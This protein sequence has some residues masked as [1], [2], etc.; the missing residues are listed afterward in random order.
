MI[1]D[2][3]ELRSFIDHCCKSTNYSFQ[4][5]KCSKI[6]CNLCKPVRMAPSK[7]ESIEFLPDPIPGDDG[8]Y[9]TFAD[10]YGSETTEEHR[11]SLIESKKKTVHRRSIDF[12]STRQHVTNVVV[13]I[14]CEEYDMWRLLFCRKKLNSQKRKLL[15]EFLED[16]SYTC[17]DT[18]TDYEMPSGLGGICIKDHKCHDTIEKLYYSCPDFEPICYYCGTTKLPSP[19]TVDCYPQ[20]ELCSLRPKVRKQQS[21]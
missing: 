10:V 13:V 6:D 3:S 8:H 5:K 7:F 12:Y 15:E 16:L 9:K 4:I 21:K 18:F 14:Q 19:I 2:K 20:C 11:P 1:E 17:G